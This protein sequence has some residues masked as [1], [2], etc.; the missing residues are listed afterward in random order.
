MLKGFNHLGLYAKDSK[1]LIEWYTD[2]LG[3]EVTK[4]AAG[5]YFLGLPDGS[6]LQIIVAED[7]GQSPQGNE[8]GMHHIAFTV[9]EFDSLVNK[10]LEQDLEVLMEPKETDDGRKLFS[11]R[12][13]EGNFIQFVYYI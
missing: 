8:S 12:D 3:F 13:I 2:T 6:Y 4:D 11:F 1:R 5:R 10:I 9:D 7:E